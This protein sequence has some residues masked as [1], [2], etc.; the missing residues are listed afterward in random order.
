MAR[1]CSGVTVSTAGSREN[2][3]WSQALATRLLGDPRD[4]AARVER[5]LDPRMVPPLSPRLWPFVALAACGAAAA[6]Q[7]SALALVHEALEA[8][9]H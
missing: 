1:V 6:F 8:L 3:R 7:P 4:L 5:L 2:A 9:A